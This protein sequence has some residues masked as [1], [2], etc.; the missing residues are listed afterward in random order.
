MVY[1][2]INGKTKG[3]LMHLQ[4]R[5]AILALIDDQ[6]TNCADETPVL[7]VVN[8]LDRDEYIFL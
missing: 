5:K 6:C 8:N 2:I 1:R 7:P 3:K 4:E